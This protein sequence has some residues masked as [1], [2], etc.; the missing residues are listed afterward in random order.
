M[1]LAVNG[2][3]LP[4]GR[5]FVIRHFRIKPVVNASPGG[6]TSF[7]VQGLAIDD[8]TIGHAAQFHHKLAFQRYLR[9]HD[10][11]AVTIVKQVEVGANVEAQVV[12]EAHLGQCLGDAAVLQRERRHDMAVEDMLTDVL[13]NPF[14]FLN[15]R[16]RF[17]YY[18]LYKIDII[19]FLL[20]FRRDDVAGVFRGDGEGYE[21]GRHIHVLEG[22]AHGIL[23]AEGGEAEL[24][25]HPHAAQHGGA[26]LAPAGRLV[27]HLLEILLEGEAYLLIIATHGH[28]FG[29]RFQ[30]GEHGG[31]ERRTHGDEGVVAE[32]H[33]RCGV[34]VSVQHRQF[35][36]RG[37][38]FRQ[39]A[40]A[41]EGHQHGSG[42]DG[43]VEHLDQTLLRSHIGIGEAVHHLVLKGV[44]HHG[45]ALQHIV[46]DGVDDG[47]GPLAHAVGVDEVAAEVDDGLAAP[48]HSQAVVVGDMGDD[49]GLDVLL[50]A[51]FEEGVHVVL[52]HHHAHAL[53]RFA[54]GHFG[55]VEALVFGSDRV[56]VDA[57]SVGQ[58][59]D[60]H[61]HAAGTEVVGL[62]H[63]AGNFRAAEEVLYLAFLGGVAFLHLGGAGV[64][65]FFVVFLGRARGAA[66]AV[67]ARAPAEHDDDVARL[68]PL[69]THM[70]HR[71]GTHHGPDF[72]SLG[73]VVVV[74]NLA[75][76]RGGQAYLVAVGRIS[77]GGTLGDDRLRQF[78]LDGVA[79][80]RV[81][82]AGTRHAESLIDVAAPAQRVADGPAYA[83]GGPAKRL[84]LRGM[85]VRL[86]LEHQQPFLRLSVHIHCDIDAA[87]V[88]LLRH[89]H[90]GQIA[91]LA[92]KL[93]VDAGHIHQR[94]R[95]HAVAIHLPP[96][97]QILVVG[98]L[99]LIL[100]CA[101][102]EN[103][104]GQFCFKGGV[105]AVVAPV[106]VQKFD[107]RVGGLAMFFV[108][109]IF[110][111]E[112]QILQRHG[113]AHLSTEIF[114]LFF[115]PRGE[116]VINGHV[117][118]IRIL[119]EFEARQVFFA[120]LHLVDAIF[121]DLS[122]LLRSQISVQDVEVGALDDRL[123][124][125]IQQRK[126]LHGA[127]GALVELAGQE[128]HGEAGPTIQVHLFI[129]IVGHRFGE[130]GRLG[131][132]QK[133]LLN[134]EDVI[135]L[136]QAKVGNI[137][138]KVV[139]KSFFQTAGLHI[140]ALFFFYENTNVAHKDVF[141]ICW[142]KYE[143][144]SK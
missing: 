19:S 117:L 72:Q 144:I 77:G 102:S 126:A 91:A 23:A 30:D 141:F 59:A 96:H 124:L 38:R 143:I 85:V 101:G 46:G 34:G 73:A 40:F 42:S 41:A 104:V 110:L 20:K 24:P 120:G 17:F 140:E 92:L 97:G 39:L 68:W 57:Q 6:K 53:L 29:H 132:L 15:I 13:E 103:D 136:Q 4:D 118:H 109:E 76:M 63:Q 10:E 123:R 3:L 127:V 99:Q 137:D 119:G 1:C 35:L 112:L 82:V 60:S 121:L 48:G 28:D 12:A 106:R 21:G 100:Q 62:L 138:V 88:V 14:C 75:H 37:L 130:N 95:L 89:F 61:A 108:A 55:A 139:V 90:V 71:R 58:L 116:S 98:F 80:G 31:V 74:V 18:I 45:L 26:R 66:D 54:D 5:R 65:G 142:Q 44:A 84:N 128:L 52:V 78:A 114:Q 70:I 134:M 11:T 27:P 67:A 22:A 51:V 8:E 49:V 16:K 64:E 43:G 107:F 87:R 50:T 69:A 83:C 105:A 111:D 32:G 7:F 33:D 81:D 131:F 25:Q 2:K 135:D 36:H 94:L 133:S 9:L 47:F 129:N 115:C 113:Q 122:E 79:D 86:V 56:Q 125:G 93:A